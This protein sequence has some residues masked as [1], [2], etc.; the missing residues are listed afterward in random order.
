MSCLIARAA[1]IFAV[2]SVL[3]LSACATPA[4]SPPLQ[5]ADLQEL[6]IEHIY[7]SLDEPLFDRLQRDRITLGSRTV[8][9]ARIVT[10]LKNSFDTELKAAGLR[11]P[12][13]S[14]AATLD[15]RVTAI[16]DEGP[17]YRM[18][19]KAYLTDARSTQQIATYQL[20][21]KYGTGGVFEKI[22]QGMADAFSSGDVLIRLSDEMAQSLRAHIYPRAIEQAGSADY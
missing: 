18:E 7:V 20:S 4:P 9:E 6:A 3:H 15:V 21:S 10:T 1:G 16:E 14:R 17:P 22:G 8:D 12:P 2:L 13:G 19:A 5:S 11:L